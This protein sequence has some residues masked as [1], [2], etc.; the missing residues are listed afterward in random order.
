MDEKI[1]WT[2]SYEDIINSIEDIC[3]C[4]KEKIEKYI[5][6]SQPFTN[7]DITKINVERFFQCIGIE[8]NNKLEL[9]NMIKFDSCVISHVTSRIEEPDKCDIYSLV[10]SLVLPTTLNGFL[11]S[12]GLVFKEENSKI[13]TYYN[14]EIVDWDKF[15]ED[16]VYGNIGRVKNR[17]LTEGRYIDNCI[18]GFLFNDCF[19]KD[20]DVSQIVKCPEIILDICGIL[21]KFDIIDEWKKASIPY[22]L[23]FLAN[24]KDITI[25]EY[26][27]YKTIKSKIYLIYKF[28]IYYLIQKH[29]NKWDECHDNVKLRLK[30]N[31]SVNK[32]KIVGFYKIEDE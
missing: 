24:I 30:D 5:E 17:L 21:N 2:T 3:G 12:K 27:N 29:Y 23:G 1:L 25:D 15:D 4:K 10:D 26:S 14:N 32:D 20:S 19:W 18:N 22:A 11:S 9:F 6:A 31:Y 16:E 7:I 8:F 13:Q 28:I